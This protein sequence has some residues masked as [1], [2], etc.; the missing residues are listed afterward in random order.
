MV[1]TEGTIGTPR[2]G[3]ILIKTTI[4]LALDCQY[5]TVAIIYL[6]DIDHPQLKKKRHDTHPTNNKSLA[7]VLLHN[8]NSLTPLTTKE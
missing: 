4:H 6:K 5:C 2:Q 3:R 1:G 8:T 7:C